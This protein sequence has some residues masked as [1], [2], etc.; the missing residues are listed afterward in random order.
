VPDPYTLEQAEDA[1]GGLRGDLD[2]IYEHLQTNRVIAEDPASPGVDE[3]WHSL[4]ALGAHYTVVL[5]RY[6]LTT[7]N[8]VELDISVNG[9]GA[10][11]TSVTFANTL[12]A[13][14]RPATT[15]DKLPMGTGHAVTGGDIWPILKVDTAGNVVVTNQ[16]TAHNYSC[17]VRVPL[18]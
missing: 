10:Q 4:G 5:G 3:S 13:A 12:P 2:R 18:D 1:I 16:G 17:V 14:Y 7:D 11:A 9:D 6:R 15:H 8:C